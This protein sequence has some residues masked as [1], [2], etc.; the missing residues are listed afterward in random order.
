MNLIT[1]EEEESFLKR[2]NSLNSESS[3]S[4]KTEGGYPNIWL[5]EILSQFFAFWYTLVCY[6]FMQ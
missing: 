1:E 4:S 2:K 6:F 3:N 5:V